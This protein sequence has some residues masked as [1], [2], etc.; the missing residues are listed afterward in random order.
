MAAGAGS[1]DALGNVR[2]E[3]TAELGRYGFGTWS[4]EGA[5]SLVVEDPEVEYSHSFGANFLLVLTNTSDN[6]NAL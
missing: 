5:H 1:W 3:P 2:K 4:T 6:V